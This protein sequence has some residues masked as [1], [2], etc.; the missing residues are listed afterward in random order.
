MMLSQVDAAMEFG[1]QGINQACTPVHEVNEKMK[2]W[3][4]FGDY[5]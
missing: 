1:V 4:V 3:V 5:I 2:E